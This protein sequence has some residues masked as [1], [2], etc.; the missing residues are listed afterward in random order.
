MPDAW[1]DRDRLVLYGSLRRGLP[2]FARLGLDR[3]LAWLGPCAV[4]GALY[5][6]GAY[7]GFSPASRSLV[8]ADLFAVC[9]GA[10]LGQL[11]AFEHYVPEDPAASLY[12]RRRIGLERPAGEA[13]IYVYN[14]NL[15]DVPLVGSG[16]W[17]AHLAARRR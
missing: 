2:D 5:D 15:A 1:A 12:L 11:D 9:D 3:A 16:D 8:H 14:G 17:P 6:L 7:P 10:V 13:W 4:R